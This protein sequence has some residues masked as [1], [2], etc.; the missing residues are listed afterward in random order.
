[1]FGHF[2]P[3]MIS[4]LVKAVLKTNSMRDFYFPAMVSIASISIPHFHEGRLLLLLWSQKCD[5]K[6]EHSLKMVLK[7]FWQFSEISLKEAQFSTFLLWMETFSNIFKERDEVHSQG[8]ACCS[9]RY[10][11]NHKILSV[12]VH[13]DHL[14]ISARTVAFWILLG[15]T[16]PEKLSAETQQPVFIWCT[17]CETV[18]NSK[19]FCQ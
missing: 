19:D 12:H 1:M 4:F 17:T 8:R 2:L 10:F 6:F 15:M 13:Y 7:L 3:P 16:S 9:E 14:D 5:R 18:R 11:I